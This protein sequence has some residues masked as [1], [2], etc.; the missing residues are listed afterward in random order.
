VVGAGTAGP[1]AALFLAR[2]G[3][4]VTLYERVAAPS[5]VGAGIVLQ[6]SGMSVLAELGLLHDVL[7]RGAVLRELWCQNARG[8][9]VIHLEYA[10]LAD[11]LYGLGLHRGVL[12]D[13]LFQAVRQTPGLG[14]QL[15]VTLDGFERGRDRRL[16]LIDVEGQRFG[17]HDLVIIADGARSRLRERLATP[18]EV[19][20]YPWGALWFVAKD[21]R[22]VFERRLFQVVDGTQ[23]LLGLL[24]TGLGPTGDVPRVSLFWSLRADLLPAWRAA[25]LD[26]WKA[27]VRRYAPQADFVLEQIG[28]VDDVLFSEYHD[29]V[30]PDWHADGV[31]ILGDAAHATSPQLGQGCNLALVDALELSR[32]LAEH[33]ELPAA[34]HDYSRR[35][36]WHLGYYQ[37]ATRWLTPLFQSDH[38]WLAPLRD[39]LLGTTCRWPVVGRQML[40]GMAGIS[41]GPLLPTMPLGQ[42][43]PLLPATTPA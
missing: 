38:G 10:T 6:P 29:V 14:L 3:H 43:P 12:F 41:R 18:A 24:P 34:L 16:T 25:G 31:V 35:R 37:L 5:T 36:R 2:A 8:R 40:T 22:R 4:R 15:G 11:D 17:P 39:V 28:S 42:R 19:T 7:A 30:M 33:D 32:A 21:E 27:D 26:A 13:A 9:R 1:A 20:R 23:R